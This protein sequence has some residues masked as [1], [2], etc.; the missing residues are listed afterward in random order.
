MNLPELAP[1]T[2]LPHTDTAGKIWKERKHYGPET[3]VKRCSPKVTEK[4]K[5]E[6]PCKT[7]PRGQMAQA[8]RAGQPRAVLSHVQRA[9]PQRAGT[10][11]RPV[12]ASGSG[13]ANMAASRPARTPRA[14][15]H[16]PQPAPRPTSPSARRRP[17][18]RPPPGTGEKASLARGPPPGHPRKQLGVV[19]SHRPLPLHETQALERKRGTR[20]TQEST[21]GRKTWK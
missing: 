17:R 11:R 4:K 15:A 12:A 16:H 20:A 2:P 21:P 8:A 19:P 9:H 6:N 7:R 18:G 10:L 14:A 1:S 13:G 5:N 3:A